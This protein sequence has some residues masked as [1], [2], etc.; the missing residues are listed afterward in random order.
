MAQKSAGAIRVGFYEIDKTIGR[1]NFAVVK[2]ARH[3]ITKTQVHI[4]QALPL[5][6]ISLYI[7]TND[8]KVLLGGMWTI[9][10][11]HMLDNIIIDILVLIL[12]EIT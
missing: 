10:W 7:F 2:L 5:I 12:G 11:M 6:L 9:L 3:R 8:L 1:G 4:F